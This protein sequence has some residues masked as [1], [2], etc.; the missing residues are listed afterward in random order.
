VAAD[1]SK[2]FVADVPA[3]AGLPASLP[4]IV[5]F[6]VLLFTPRGKL[7]EAS[8]PAARRAGVEHR[9]FPVPLRTAGW[10][11]LLAVLVAVPHVVGPRLPVF[12][13]AT[14]FILVFAS[15]RLLVRTSGQVSLCHAGFA[16]VGAAS[17]SHLAHGAHLPWLVA[18]VLAGV[19]TV[20]LGA[21]VAIPAI[22][23]SGLYL[24]L[25]T[26]GFGILLER[27][28]YNTFLIFGG[29]GARPA[30]RPEWFSGDTG[31]Y[32]VCLAVAVAGIVATQLLGRLRL[33]QLLRALA[34]SPLALSTNGANVNVTRVLAFCISA[35]MAG[36]AGALLAA[37]A[38]SINGTGFAALN[39]LLWL[40][41]LAISGAGGVTAPV[42]AAG[43]LVVVP[44]YASS[45]GY[46]EAQPILFGVAAVV[47]AL[48]SSG[49][50]DFASRLAAAQQ[51]ARRSPVAE[52]YARS[53]GA[54]AARPEPALPEPLS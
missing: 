20:P 30:P 11:A 39:S 35:F 36:I 5:L 25:A 1:L 53:L 2:R 38:G 18:L 49:N 42:L 43:L 21:V 12:T 14:I 3:L 32:Y 33:G 8:P 27:M 29:S 23:L 37:Q 44:S 19:V 45:P 47:A 48:V 34:D 13:A 6:A 52:R 9:P 24:A 46:L 28:A 17:F 10:V 51:R 31:F 7:V 22:R 26:F 50:V 54:A 15:L 16:A 4:F 41:V 40:A